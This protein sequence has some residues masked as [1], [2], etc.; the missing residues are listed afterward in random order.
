MSPSNDLEKGGGNA[1]RGEHKRRENRRVKGKKKT[2]QRE[3]KKRKRGRV[4]KNT[5]NR[6]SFFLAFGCYCEE[7]GEKKD[8]TER[9]ICC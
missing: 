1:E 8:K 2:Q 5:V 7:R 6:G 9:E 4:K 3:T